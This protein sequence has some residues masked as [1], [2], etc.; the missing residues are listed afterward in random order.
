MSAIH[1]RSPHEPGNP[2]GVTTAARA[3]GR[4]ILTGCS[5]S[6]TAGGWF[7][8][9]L[10]PCMPRAPDPQAESKDEMTTV[11]IHREGYPVV[12]AWRASL[13]AERM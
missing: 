2:I 6:V 9:P 8:R 4:K 10:T 7:S 1:P 11:S 3:V 12:V 5:L 13:S